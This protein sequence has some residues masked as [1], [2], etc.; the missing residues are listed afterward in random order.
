MS[1]NGNISLILDSVFDSDRFFG[2]PKA[3]AK[4]P[5]ALPRVNVIEKDDAFYLEAETPGMTQNDVS[6]ELHN[7]ILTIKGHREKSSENDDND[8]RI[9][10]FSEQRFAR[11]FRL[12]DQIDSD[13]VIAS[14]DRGVLK[15]SLAKKEQEKPK[16]IEIKVSP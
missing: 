6:I 3:Q 4:H 13:K 15:V 12:S 1:D 7:G 10:E 2:F 8:Y 11:S 5:S 16:N 14:M 9:R